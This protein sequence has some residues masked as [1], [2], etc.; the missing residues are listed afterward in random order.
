MT[1]ALLV[2]VTSRG[3]RLHTAVDTDLLRTLVPSVLATATWTRP[4]R[5][6]LYIGYDAGDPFY[7][8]AE[9]RRAIAREI[10]TLAGRRGLEVVFHRAHGTDHSPCAVW[11]ALF[12]RAYEEGADYFYQLGD[13]VALLTTGWAE[14]FTDALAGNPTAAGLGVVGPVDTNRPEFPILTQ[15]LVSRL[16]LEIFGTLYPSAFRNWFSDNWLTDVYSPQHVRR[17]EAQRSHNAGGAERYVIDP[18][19]AELLAREVP[20]GRS[21]LRGWLTR[22]SR[23]L[24]VPEGLPLGRRQRARIYYIPNGHDCHVA[25]AL[26]RMYTTVTPF[27]S[28]DVPDYVEHRILAHETPNASRIMVDEVKRLRPDLVYAES[29]YNIDADALAFVR[30]VLKVPV[31]MWYGDPSSPPGEVDRLVNYA[32]A[33]DWQV[34]VDEGPVEA[35]RDQGLDNV[36]SIPYFGYDHY[37]H[38]TKA[39]KRIDVLFSG[40]SYDRLE[41]LYP[42]AG[43]RRALIRQLNREIGDRLFVIGEG[44]N[45]DRLRNWQPRR[46]PEWDV[47]TLNNQSRIV[48]AYD[49]AQLP[50]FTSLRAW[51]A[52]LSGAF[53]LIRRFPGIETYFENHRHL[54]WFDDEDEASA[55]VRRYLA[56]DRGRARIARTGHQLIQARGWK[57]STLARYLVARG[58]GTERRRFAEIHGGLGPA[59]AA[60]ARRHPAARPAVTLV[61]FATP[62]WAMACER[63]A[64]SALEN[65]VDRVARYGTQD[66]LGSPFHFEHLQLLSGRKGFG[67]WIWKPYFIREVLRRARPGEILIYADAGSTI[68][69]PVAPLVQIA[70][71]RSPIVAFGLHGHANR[72]WIKRD[73]FIALDCDT[74]RY[75]NAEAW[76]GACQVY[77]AGPESLAFVEAWLRACTTGRIVTDEPNELGRRN[78]PGFREHRHDQSLFSLLC[79]K[80]GLER[81]RDPSQW[82][83]AIVLANSPYGQLLHHHRRRR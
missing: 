50:G 59:R 57:F 20:L 16:H 71:D 48:L 4:F 61:T 38:P 41:T 83:N 45:R 54:V 14:A 27:G 80:H 40:K 52:L 73:A 78:L 64:A 25:D 17:I 70:R 19:G 74:P 18:R 24:T 51:N 32:R 31:T 10:R 53:V 6:R 69:A 43:R 8:T 12:A 15:A 82:G 39:A 81:F 76:N 42:E 2:P 21:R 66:L 60:T 11:N 72:T 55:L 9:G 1:I 67:Y 26:Q 77:R 49:A 23:D 47:N 29:A 46:V 7:D 75:W 79:E 68:M 65:G 37:F 58:R 56:D 62:D 33:V 3:R 35:A 34:V 30:R 36:E 13:D 22:A 44:W 5:Y 63:L 28:R